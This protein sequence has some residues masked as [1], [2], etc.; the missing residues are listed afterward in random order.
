MVC[1]GTKLTSLLEYIP[2]FFHQGDCNRSLVE[3][4]KWL[5]ID[6]Y[7][8][9]QKFVSENFAAIIMGK[10]IGLI[11]IYTFND[12][13]KPVIIGGHGHTLDLGYKRYLS[14]FKRI[15][16]WYQ[17]DPWIKGTQA[18]KDMQFTH[19]LHL[20][21]S[22]KLR[23]LDNEQIDAASKIAEPWCPDREIFLKDFAT[24]CPF[25]K[26]AQFPF[27]M[28][29]ESP[30]R[31]KGINNMDLASVQ[32][33]FVGMFVLRP[34]DIG[35]H[36]ATDEDIESF[37][38]M[39]RCY[40]YFLGLEDEHN[41]FRGSFEEIKQRTQDFFQYWIT[42]N[43]KI[44]TPEWEHMTRCVIVP[45]NYYRFIYMPYKAMVLIATDLL[46]LKMPNLYASLSYSEWIAYKVY[47]FILQHALKLSIIRKA[48]NKLAI[49]IL[50]T[51]VNYSS[52]KKPELKKNQ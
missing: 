7:R 32:A 10:L 9:G 6:K 14:T 21:M 12:S 24:A 42:P 15:L 47:T 3:I 11:H 37:C 22:E 25:E 49:Y 50:N 17:G 43:F 48:M 16:S 27:T 23:K 28:M 51:A 4:P 31:P 41:F 2:A 19:K 46:D 8:K 20:L 40:G 26:F 18:Y 52:E 39:W 35:V 13:L 33:A 36:N 45:M 44:I 30:Y 34:Q 29:S 38:H 5:D 1:K